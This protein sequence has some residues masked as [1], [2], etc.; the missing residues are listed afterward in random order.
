VKT[1]SSGMMVRLAFAVQVL[2]DPDILIIDEALSVGDFFFQQKC[3]SYIRGLKERGVTLLFV[4]HDMGAVRDVCERGIVLDRGSVAFDGENIEAIQYYL[5]GQREVS[6]TENATNTTLA[7]GKTADAEHEKKYLWSN[8]K[9]YY[10][11]PNA[12]LVHVNILN[13]AAEPALV[14]KIDECI[15]VEATFLFH[16]GPP[17]DVTVVIKNK[18]GHLVTSIGT[19]NERVPFPSFQAGRL[20]KSTIKFN[21]AFEAGDYSF[22]V[23]LGRATD[24]G[25]GIVEAE[26]PWLGPFTIR[27][28]YTEERPRFYGMFGPEYTA[29]FETIIK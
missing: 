13:S 2:S 7:I 8:S 12:E 24:Q 29:D 3:M 25:T 22:S 27:W 28:P 5:T 6:G 1:Y 26:T 19:F 20:I 16:D 21:A 9:E 15:S 4:S 11:F 18:H 14:F 23:S 10:N 17:V